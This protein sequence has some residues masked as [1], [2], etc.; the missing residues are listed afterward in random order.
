ME[1]LFDTMQLVCIALGAGAAF[2]FDS[3]FILSL[4]HHLLRPYETS[5]LKRISLFSIVASV[6]GL[7]AY[8][9][10][11][12]FA[13]EEAADFPLAFISAKTVFFCLAFITALTL[14]RIHLGT[15]LRYQKSYA[16]LS[17]SMIIHHDAL[18][19]TAAYS[20]LSWL[21]LILMTAFETGSLP[22]S[23]PLSFPEMM[24]LF[25]C[26][27]LF[28]SHISIYAKKRMIR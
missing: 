19:S 24:I 12:A 3:F 17:E 18:I 15:L 20:T 14:R 22:S 21:A 28:V 16:H 5:A 4:K 10:G 23:S 2:I 8:I 7:M 1:L 9:F 25:I 6:I 11:L 26:I 27:G 13:F